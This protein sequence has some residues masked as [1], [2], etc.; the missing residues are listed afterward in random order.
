MTIENLSTTGFLYQLMISCFSKL[1]VFVGECFFFVRLA[2]CDHFSETTHPKLNRAL[3]IIFGQWDLVHHGDKS[4]TGLSFF[5]KAQQL[6]LANKF[7]LSHH[8]CNFLFW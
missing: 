7:T 1:L 3:T 5:V 4:Y 8:A 2:F 6:E